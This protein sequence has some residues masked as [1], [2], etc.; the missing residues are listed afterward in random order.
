[1]NTPSEAKQAT[2]WWVLG[3]ALM[4]FITFTIIA[5][6]VHEMGISFF[7]LAFHGTVNFSQWSWFWGQTGYSGNFTPAEMFIIDSGGTLFVTL[8]MLLLIAIPEPLYTNITAVVLGM[9]NLIDGFPALAGSD[10]F[11]AAKV[12]V[13]GAW[14]WYV[15][16]FVV[17]AL[18]IAYLAGFRISLKESF[19]R[20]WY[21]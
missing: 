3:I 7:V 10:G 14:V 12:S 8:F 13:V 18:A 20:K 16:I 2:V 4:A 19:S 9:R 6:V 21:K 15:I 11:Q 17:W 1:M 5:T